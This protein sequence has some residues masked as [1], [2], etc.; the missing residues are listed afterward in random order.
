MHSR[1]SLENHTR[2][3]TKMGKVYTRLPADQNGSKTLPSRAAYTYL[4]YIRE[5][6]TP[7]AP[8]RLPGGQNGSRKLT[9]SRFPSFSALTGQIGR[10]GVKTKAFKFVVRDGGVPSSKTSNFRLLFMTFG[11][12]ECLLLKLAY[13]CKG[14]CL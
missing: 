11:T 4:A 8:F 5:Y 1:S 9:F 10:A 7:L 2:F 12:S 14:D 13:I 3:H 6:P